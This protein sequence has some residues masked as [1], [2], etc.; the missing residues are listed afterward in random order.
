MWNYNYVEVGDWGK[1]IV[2]IFWTT[3]SFSMAQD[4]VLL[5]TLE[6]WLLV[7]LADIHRNLLGHNFTYTFQFRVLDIYNERMMSVWYDLVLKIE[8]LLMYFIINII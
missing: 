8:K 4:N 3:S 2:D 5:C 1:H 6:N 7:V